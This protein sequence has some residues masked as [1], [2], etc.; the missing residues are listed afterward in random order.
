MELLVQLNA[1]LGVDGEEEGG[2][3]VEDFAGVF[4]WVGALVLPV[5][6]DFGAYVSHSKTRY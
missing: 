3:D 5:D 2:Q 1:D 6:A 4:G